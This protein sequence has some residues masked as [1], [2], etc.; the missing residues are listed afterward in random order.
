MRLQARYCARDPDHC[1]SLL[2]ASLALAREQKAKLWE[3]RTA[4]TLAE[5]WRDQNRHPEA[6][7]LLEPIHGW[8]TEGLDMPDLVA[9]RRLLSELN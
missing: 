8:F 5:L 9:A 2:Q 7:T 4:T 1:M 6:R 3:L